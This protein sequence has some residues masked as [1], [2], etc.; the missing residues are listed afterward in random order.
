MAIQTVNPASGKV[1]RV[2][3]ASSADEIEKMLD[4]A[5][6][7][8]FLWS[9]K[10]VDERASFLKNLAAV[11]EKG[12]IK[13]A[14]LAT[15]EMGRVL[16]DSLSEI[17]KSIKICEYYEKN[18]SRFLREQHIPTEFS[19][20]Y[21][22]YSPLGVIFGIMPWNYPFTQ[23][24]RAIIPAITA[25]NVFVLKHASSV[26]QCSME[27]VRIF[28]KAGFPDGVFTN[29]L[30]EGEEALKV[31]SDKRIAAVTLTGSERSGALVASVS[32]KNLKKCVLELGGSD[33]FI[34]L[35]D[36]DVEE[37][38]LRALR[39]RMTNAGQACNSPKRIILSHKI[40]KKFKKM[41]VQMASELVVG[42]PMDEKTNVGPLAKEELMRTIERQISGSLKRGAKILLGGRRV[43]RDGFYFEVTIVDRVIAGMPLFD[44]EV[45]GPVVSFI[46]VR[47]DEEAIKVANDTH[48][49]LSA[50]VWTK[51]IKRAHHFIDNLHVGLVFVNQIVR[52]DPRLPYGGVKNSGYGRELGEHGIREFTNIKSVVIK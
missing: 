45:F 28:R 46:S 32:G 29:L 39:G 42:N 25:G 5:Q 4:R 48:L 7:T 51:D 36:A 34:V 21:I 41:F 3:S 16:T 17:D 13:Y 30:L 24:L 52:S 49:G 50:S 19:K 6:K 8:F 43:E 15:L 10:S 2:F 38:A 1:E 33:A 27:L 35:E 20:S 40:E 18:A 12:K 31:I 23:A 14:K 11:L 22:E 47:S 37:A 26:P 44:E 9:R